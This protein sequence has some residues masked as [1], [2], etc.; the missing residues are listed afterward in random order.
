MSAHAHKALLL[1]TEAVDF[2]FDDEPPRSDPCAPSSSKPSLVDVWKDLID[3]L[4]N[5][6]NSGETEFHPVVDI[7]VHAWVEGCADFELFPTII[8]STGAAIFANQ[9][10]HTAMLLLLTH[11]PRSLSPSHLKSICQS[12]VPTASPLWHAQRVCAIA[13]NNDLQQCWDPCLVSSLL[14]AAKRITHEGQQ[15]AIIKRMQSIEQMTGWD[16]GL[17]TTSLKK[18]WKVERGP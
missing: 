12:K 17:V 8:F 11:R 7:H 9:L 3:Q 10:Y 13:L 2:C 6:Y 15:R 18:R 4:C 16:L 1:C 5:W 14:I